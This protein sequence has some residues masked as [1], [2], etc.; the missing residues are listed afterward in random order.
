MGTLEEDKYD[1]CKPQP[2]QLDCR[3]EW[4]KFHKD[5]SC[6]HDAP[7]LTVNWLNATCWTEID[8]RDENDKKF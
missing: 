6:T 1:M 7:A 8:E 4:C 5:G 2:V 3:R